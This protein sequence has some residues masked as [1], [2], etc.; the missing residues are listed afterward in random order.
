MLDLELPTAAPAAV[1]T[2]AELIP[3]KKAMLPL[4][5][6]NNPAQPTGE[7]PMLY[8]AVYH[9]YSTTKLSTTQHG[10]VQCRTVQHSTVRQA[11]SCRHAHV[12][13]TSTQQ[14][15]R[16]AHRRPPPDLRPPLKTPHKKTPKPHQKW[17]SILVTTEQSGIHKRR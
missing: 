13:S 17:I 7:Q 8:S 5:A 12:C 4:P 3:E 16:L 2:W 10:I 11:Q 9:K 14:K 6:A 1:S 15:L